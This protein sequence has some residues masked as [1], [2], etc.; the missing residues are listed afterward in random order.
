M[1]NVAPLIDAQLKSARE[2]GKAGNLQPITVFET[3]VRAHDARL[4]IL[5]AAGDEATA[6]ST[7]ERL[8]SSM[9]YTP[10]REKP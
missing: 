3:L 7:M 9:S 1:L 2:L 10:S 4:E 6:V 8:L 5:E